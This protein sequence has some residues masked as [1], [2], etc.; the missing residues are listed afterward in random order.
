M[1]SHIKSKAYTCRFGF[2]ARGLE[3]EDRK[4]HENEM[5]IEHTTCQSRFWRLETVTVTC[6]VS[7]AAH[8]H[9][10]GLGIKVGMG[11][12]GAVSRWA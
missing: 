9:P 3:R 2:K 11:S 7:G 5:S 12:W 1:T 6:R 4:N 10:L 8:E